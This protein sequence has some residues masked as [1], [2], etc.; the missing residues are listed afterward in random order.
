MPSRLFYINNFG[1][2]DEDK[3]SPYCKAH[4]RFCRLLLTTLKSDDFLVDADVATV[5]VWTQVALRDQASGS[6]MSTW[7]IVSRPLVTECSCSD[8][9]ISKSW[10]RKKYFSNTDCGGVALNFWRRN[11]EMATVE[12]MLCF[13]LDSM[14]MITTWSCFNKINV[15]PP[16][17]IKF[18]DNFQR[19]HRLQFWPRNSN[20]SK[21]TKPRKWRLSK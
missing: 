11:F 13:L 3:F 20:H 14:V 4:G 17:W 7:S 2:C 1:H 5:R 21:L 15:L 19:R 6:W 8:V 12:F 18:S 9:L 10:K 16:S